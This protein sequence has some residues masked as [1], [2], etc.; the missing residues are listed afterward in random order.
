MLSISL[1]YHKNGQ[2][3]NVLACLEHIHCNLK[4]HSSILYTYGHNFW[5][6]LEILGFA[7][8]PSAGDS[9]FD[10]LPELGAPRSV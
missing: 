4:K 5:E 10:S 9:S 3:V 6:D 2:I 7:S 1:G 8:D